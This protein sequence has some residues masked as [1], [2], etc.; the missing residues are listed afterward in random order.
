[1]RVPG[2]QFITIL[3]PCEYLLSLEIYMFAQMDVFSF[4]FSQEVV[5][6]MVIVN[7][8]MGVKQGRNSVSASFGINRIFGQN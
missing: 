3:T 5:W 1:M 8:C 4:F 6:L 7:Y 2:Q